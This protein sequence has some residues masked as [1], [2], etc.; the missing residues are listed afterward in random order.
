MSLYFSLAAAASFSATITSIVLLASVGKKKKKTE[1]EF[2][3]RSTMEIESI[4]PRKD[5][6]RIVP[7]GKTDEMGRAV[8]DVVEV[9]KTGTEQISL[10]DLEPTEKTKISPETEPVSEETLSASPSSE[11]HIDIAEIIGNPLLVVEKGADSRR[12]ELADGAVVLGRSPDVECPIP[13]LTVSRK[14]AR[15]EKRSDGFYLSDLNSKNGTF[16][17]GT[18]I[19]GP[20]RVQPG[21]KIEIGEIDLRFTRVDS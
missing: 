14:H 10:A 1:P 9:T 20:T 6:E 16:L 8:T 21:D 19:A 11:E 7:E 5:T 4:T 13:S 17:N 3:D 12:W 15:L 18:K 2:S